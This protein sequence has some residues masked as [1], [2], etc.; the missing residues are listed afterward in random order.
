MDRW[1]YGQLVDFQ[2]DIMGRP[3]TRNLDI[4]VLVLV[5]LPIW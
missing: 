4:Y 1:T 3:H 2:D 5:L